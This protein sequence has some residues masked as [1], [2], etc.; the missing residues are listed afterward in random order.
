VSQ[1]QQLTAVGYKTWQGVRAGGG[2][3]HEWLPTA[4]RHRLI[5]LNSPVKREVCQ[6]Q[7]EARRGSH[8]TD[9]GQTRSI[10]DR[11][12]VRSV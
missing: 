10:L 11:G 8:Q 5:E 12:Q 7:Y 4:D 3:T 2:G 9:A 6:V 1:H